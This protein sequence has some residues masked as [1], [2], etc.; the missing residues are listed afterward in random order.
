MTTPHSP[1]PFTNSANR[2]F[3]GEPHVWEN[4]KR[5][6]AGSSGFQRWQLEHTGD[7]QFQTLNLDALVHSYLKET[8]ETLAY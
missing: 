5:A 4:L 1:S 2:A 6:I 3:T 7:E 8:L